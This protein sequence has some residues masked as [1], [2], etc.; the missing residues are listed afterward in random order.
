MTSRVGGT[1]TSV[2]TAKGKLSVQCQCSVKLLLQILSPSPSPM[3]S[4]ALEELGTIS[5]LMPG[6]QSMPV[7]LLT[8]VIK[9]DEAPLSPSSTLL[10]GSSPLMLTLGT[11]GEH[12]QSHLSGNY[13][14][15]LGY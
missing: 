3:V 15:A 7:L 5:E 1:P 11:A 13:L 10:W 2:T 12:K 4:L 14:E 9:T 8:K 6:L